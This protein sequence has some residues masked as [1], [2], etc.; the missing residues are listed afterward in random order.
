MIKPTQNYVLLEEVK[1]KSDSTIIIP[2]EADQEPPQLA[3]VAALGDSPKVKLKVGDTVLFK[4]H[5]FDVVT[6]GKKTYLL[7]KDEHITATVHD[8]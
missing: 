5:N 2:D 3:R 4:R 1:E 7:G 8:K 6:E